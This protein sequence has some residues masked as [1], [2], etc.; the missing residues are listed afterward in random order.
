[1]I[2]GTPIAGE[3]RSIFASCYYYNDRGEPEWPAQ[4]IN[5]TNKTQFLFRIEKGLLNVND[6]RV[7]THFSEGELRVPFRNIVYLGDSRTD[8]PC[9]KL[10]NSMGGH[11]IGI[12]EEG[13]KETVYHL[14]NDQRIRYF[15]P[16]DYKE[17]SRLDALMKAI[18]E[19]TESYEKLENFHLED[20]YEK[21][22]FADR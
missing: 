17:G 13:R 1:M 5:Y 7:N 21:E 15:A 11:S 16:A 2:E 4:A 22:G 10:V 19:K 12:Y 20:L 8:I 3:F 18:I 14:M 6:P 9:M